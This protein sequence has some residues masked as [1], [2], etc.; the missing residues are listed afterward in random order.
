MLHRGFTSPSAASDF[1]PS[2]CTNVD[3]P[4]RVAASSVLRISLNHDTLG[5][6][7]SNCCNLLEAK[8]NGCR[9]L[10]CFARHPTSTRC[11]FGLCKRVSRGLSSDS[12]VLTGRSAQVPMEQQERPSGCWAMLGDMRRVWPGSGF[13]AR[14]PEMAPG[15]SR[16]S[17]CCILGLARPLGE[18]NTA[19]QGSPRAPR[20][21]SSLPV[22]HGTK[23]RG[24]SRAHSAKAAKA[25]GFSLPRG[26]IEGSGSWR[27]GPPRCVNAG[28][29]SKRTVQAHFVE[30]LQPQLHVTCLLLIISHNMQVASSFLG[31]QKSLVKA[32]LRCEPCRE[33][34]SQQCCRLGWLSPRGFCCFPD[35]PFCLGERKCHNRDGLI[36]LPRSSFLTG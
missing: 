33:K 17:S 29:Q 31:G 12:Q 21:G 20:A 26:Q 23:G 10:R 18:T 30:C 15:P 34:S 1:R 2:E 27:Q 4:N 28:S 7:I 14:A 32:L 16:G 8:H 25:A 5:P 35:F 19:T 13:G 22:P 36:L 3:G 11:G 6:S 9:R 24:R